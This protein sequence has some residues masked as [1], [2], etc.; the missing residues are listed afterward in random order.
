MKLNDLSNEEIVFIHLMVED[1]LATL[2]EV[3][4]KGGITYIMDSP[5]GKI[6]LFGKFSEKELE[7][8]EDS[9]KYKLANNIVKKLN[10]VYDLIADGNQDVI[11]NVRRS[12][13]P[14]SEDDEEKED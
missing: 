8:L 4:D 3:L 10:P 1:R 2:N 11:D 7:D 9:V 14:K 6:E 13:F 5:L 12:L